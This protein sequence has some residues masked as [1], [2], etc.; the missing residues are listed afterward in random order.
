MISKKGL[1][2]VVIPAFNKPEYTSKTIDSLMLQTYR[3]M[4]I[5]LSDDNSPRSLKDL[6]DQK[7]SE[8]DSGLCI[9]YFRQKVNLNYYWNLQFVI[10]EATGQYIVLLDHDDWLID[11]NYFSDSIKA[12]EGHANCYLSIANTF[13]ENSPQ[14]ILNFYYN[15]WH[16][17][18]GPA[19]VKNQL[20][21]T[22]H[23]SRSTIILCLDKLKELDYKRYFVD[24]E[25]ASKMKVM[26]DEAFVLVCLLASVGNIALT[27]RVVSVRGV[28]PESLSRTALWHKTGGYKMFISHFLLYQYFKKIECRDGMQAMSHNLILRY[29]CQGINIEMIKYLNFNRLAIVFMVLG[30]LWFNLKRIILFPRQI[31]VILRSTMICIAKKIFL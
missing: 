18:D 9:K 14:T 22:I 2:S 30:V 27:G 29:P 26:P 4:E 3:P 6:V 17:V 12:I 23:P 1:I 16:Y 11:H 10:G 28:P 24:Q 7:K 31:L 13:F 5:I 25:S 19:L 8:C 15:N 21:T 20:F